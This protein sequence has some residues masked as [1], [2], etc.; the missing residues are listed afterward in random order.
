MKN[1]NS[2]NLSECATLCKCQNSTCKFRK[3]FCFEILKVIE[4]I[5]RGFLP[6]G[7]FFITI[8]DV[9]LPNKNITLV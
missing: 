9:V 4:D 7:H 2:A 6:P 1:N 3:T 5:F 8:T